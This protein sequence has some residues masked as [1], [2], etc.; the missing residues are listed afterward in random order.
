MVKVT[1]EQREQKALLRAHRAAQAAEEEDRRLEE[2]QQQ[3]QREGAYLSRA[4]LKAGEPCRGCGQP[5]LDGLGDWP[6]L[7]QLTPA[8]RA[9]YDRVQTLFAQRHADCRSHRSSTGGHRTLHCGYC[10]PPPPLSDEQIEKIALI[11]S[12]ARVRTENL[13]SWDLT[14]TC[15]H[16]VRR[17]QHR[18]HHRSA[19][20]VTDCPACQR[21]RG[22]VTAQ[23][24]GPVDDESGQVTRDR[25]AAE[26]A[27]AQAKLARQQKAL[28]A[29]ER[30]IAQLTQKLTEDGRIGCPLIADTWTRRLVTPGRAGGGASERGRAEH[31]YPDVVAEVGHRPKGHEEGAIP[32]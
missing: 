9:E 1:A 27:A 25:L 2:R 15:G 28:A 32:A 4:E 13:D 21:R 12:S 7:N 26:V 3:W 10:C 22:V 19:M 17:A 8:E 18:D 20:H 11:F 29:T 24:V 30:T 14:L 16:A 31:Y 23:R 6:A 5:L